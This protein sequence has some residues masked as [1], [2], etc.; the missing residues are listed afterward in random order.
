MGV[1]RILGPTGDVRV[2]WDATDVDDVRDMRERFDKIV[3]DGYLVFELDESTLEGQQV[4]TFDP[5]AER[6]RAFRPL[7]GG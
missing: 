1:L 7:Q 2:E 4:S 6:L 5:A 3:A